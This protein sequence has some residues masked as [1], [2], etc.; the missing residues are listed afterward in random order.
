MTLNNQETHYHITVRDKKRTRFARCGFKDRFDPFLLN[1]IPRLH[2]LYHSIFNEFLGEHPYPVLLDI[3]CGSGIYV[4][5]LSSHGQSIHALDYSYAMLKVSQAYCR[6][7]GYGHIYSIVAN[8]ETLPYPNCMFDAVVALDVLHHVNSFRSVISEVYRVLKPN[9]YFLVFEPNTANLLMWFA[10]A[11]PK[12]ERHAL[13]RNQPHQLVTLLETH[14][15]TLCWKGICELITE[16]SG[17]KRK[18][19][20]LYLVWRRL[21]GS[22]AK[23]PRQIWLG[24]KGTCA[25]DGHDGNTY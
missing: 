14:F 15:H 5:A 16:T 12:E 11:I 19:L 18:L 20:E 23:Y 1:A 3:G 2:N 24:R 17:I 9:G 6:H 21:L 25:I 7:Q 22:E 10:H 13:H 4:D 8:A